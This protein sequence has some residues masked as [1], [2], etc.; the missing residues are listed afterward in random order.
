MFHN[1]RRLYVRNPRN[2]VT[3]YLFFLRN[4]LTPAP[5]KNVTRYKTV[6]AG[7][8]ID[9][10][11]AHKIAIDLSKKLDASSGIVPVRRALNEAH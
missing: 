6:T 2:S 4:T 7:R 8:P 9:V 3:K 5:R 11:Q 10:F 1:F